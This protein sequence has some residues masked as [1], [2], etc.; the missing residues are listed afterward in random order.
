VTNA[1]LPAR[2]KP[3][4]RKTDAA[5]RRTTPVDVQVGRNVRRRRIELGMSQTALAT[6]CEITFQQ[7]QKYENGANRV[8]ASR[9]WQFAAVLGV[10]VVYFF[11][12]LGAPKAKVQGKMPSA[13]ERKIDDETAKIAR[14]IASISDDRLRKRLKTMLASLAYK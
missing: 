13:A 8:S 12:G 14:K 1:E 6:A 5:A 7:V 3:R 10:P 4:R 9:L 2:V 11:E